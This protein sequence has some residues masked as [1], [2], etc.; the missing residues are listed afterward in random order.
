D[1]HER[2]TM[3]QEITTNGAG[4]VDKVRH[5]SAVGELSAWNES[6][7]NTGHKDEGSRLTVRRTAEHDAAITRLRLEQSPLALFKVGIAEVIHAD[8][9]CGLVSLILGERQQGQNLPL[10]ITL[11]AECLDDRPDVGR[12]VEV[13]KSGLLVDERTSE[14]SRGPTSKVGLHIP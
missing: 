10:R 12:R 5:F 8:K 14:K 6:L 13:K 9:T 3:H 11:E 2:S 7:Y 1:E 4:E